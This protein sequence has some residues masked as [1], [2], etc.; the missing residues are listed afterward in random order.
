MGLVLTVD[1]VPY[2]QALDDE[3]LC[4][5]L[6]TEETI[7]RSQHKQ[8]HASLRRTVVSLLYT[9]VYGNTQHVAASYLCVRLLH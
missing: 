5:V 8:T 1:I 2:D 9:L 6:S 3:S 7:R 4:E